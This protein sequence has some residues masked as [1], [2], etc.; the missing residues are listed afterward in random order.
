MPK[1]RQRATDSYR[2]I[3]PESGAT[4]LGVFGVSEVPNDA[5][6]M[7]EAAAVNH[8]DQ[9]KKFAYHRLTVRYID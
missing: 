1:M 8:S 2:E 4:V 6:L 5:K 3:R 9:R 7:T